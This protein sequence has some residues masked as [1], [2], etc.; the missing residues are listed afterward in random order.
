M[1][2]GGDIYVFYILNATCFYSF[3]FEIK[4]YTEMKPRVLV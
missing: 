1:V 2:D 4:C 3:L